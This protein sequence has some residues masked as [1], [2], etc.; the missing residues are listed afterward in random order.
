MTVV[1][2][3]DPA[4]NDAAALAAVCCGRTGVGVQ[5][6]EVHLAEQIVEWLPSAEKPM[7][8]PEPRRSHRR[9]LIAFSAA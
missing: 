1:G 2:H 5:G 8:L 9:G 6:G 4:V 7:L 3:G